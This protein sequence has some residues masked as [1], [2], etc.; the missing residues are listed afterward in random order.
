[1]PNAMVKIARTSR[2]LALPAPNRRRG[3][4]HSR[5]EPEAG[6]TDR[7]EEGDEESALVPSCGSVMPMTST[8]REASQRR[9]ASPKGKVQNVC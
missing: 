5:R 3:D 6:T 2:P 7:G 4:E 8:S 1:M 9:G